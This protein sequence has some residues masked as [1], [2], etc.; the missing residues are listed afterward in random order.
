MNEIDAWMEINALK[1]E[2]ASDMFPI[3]MHNNR[4]VPI[5]RGLHPQSPASQHKG[6]CSHRRN[7]KMAFNKLTAA[8][9]LRMTA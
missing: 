6:H 8:F 7:K 2:A 9:C 1:T 3:D 4:G 5:P